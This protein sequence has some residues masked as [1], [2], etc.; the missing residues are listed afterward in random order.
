MAS[1]EVLFRQSRGAVLNVVD[2]I[3]VSVVGPHPV[4]VVEDDA[5]VETLFKITPMLVP[6]FLVEKPFRRQIFCRLTSDKRLVDQS[7]VD[8]IT[9][10]K[11]GRPKVCRSNLCRSNV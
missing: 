7:S 2:V 11:L 1:V 5:G 8:Q 6:R 9:R 10:P 3:V 4:E